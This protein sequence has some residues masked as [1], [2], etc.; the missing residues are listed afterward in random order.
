MKSLLSYLQNI[1]KTHFLTEKILIVDSYSIG[2]QIL[3]QLAAEGNH[4]VNLKVKTV[5]DL[6][7]EAFTQ[8]KKD[9]I[10]DSLGS[11]FMY[12]LLSN[13][14]SN[15]VL[16]YFNDVEVT[17]ALSFSMYQTI[18][19]LR[20]AGYT[21]VTLK[22]E[23]FVTSEKG[24]DMIRI[25]SHYEQLLE[26]HQ[27]IDDAMLY[28]RVV[29][30]YS[31]LGKVFILQSNL[32]LSALQEDFLK[33]I[34]TADYY[35]LP[36]EKV[37]GIEVPSNSELSNVVFHGETTLSYLYEVEK[38]PTK[39]TNLSLFSAQTEETELKEML[40]R[41]KQSGIRFDEAA[42]FYTAS[43]QYV[44]SMYHL[45]EK[46][47]IPVT[48]G[49]GIPL[50]YTRPGKFVTGLLNW[51]K[52]SYSVQAFITLLQENVM[53]T[54]EGAP[55]KT[56]WAGLL[57]EASIGWSPERYISQLQDQI[58]KYEEKAQDELE[59]ERQAYFQKKSQEFTWLL[60]WFTSI[61]KHMPT[62]YPDGMLIYAEQLKAIRHMLSSFGKV[63]S[64]YDQAAKEVMLEKIDELLPYANEEVLLSEAFQ[65]I[66]E[67]LLTSNV[68][69]S[70]PKP[71]HLHIS[72]YK[73]GLYINREHIFIVGLDNQRFPGNAQE[74][75][76]LLDIER[77]KLGKQ[78][79]LEKEKS[80]RNLY[81]MLQLFASAASKQITVSYCKFD[82]NENRAITPAYLFLQC[83]RIQSGQHAADFKQL[84]EEIPVATEDMTL[85]SGDWWSKKLMST[86][87]H[88]L[89][90]QLL[91]R[92]TNVER[93]L[94]A[95][96]MRRDPAFTVFEG[97][98]ESDTTQFDPRRNSE[99]SISA[100]KLEAIAKCPYSYFLENVLRI[101]V[102]EDVTY[103]PGKW[104][105]AKTRG[106]LL[107]EIFEKFYKVIKAKGEKPS[108]QRHFDLLLSLAKN[109]I[110]NIKSIVPPPNQRVFEVE[111]E[112]IIESCETFLRIEEENSELGEPLYFEYSFGQDSPAVIELP[113]GKINV[114]GIID[115]VDQL[116]DGSF[117]IIDYKTGSSWG[118]ETKE[119]FK[120][121]R[122]LQHLLYT[123]A[124][125]SH[126]NLE[127][128]TVKKS[129]YFFPTRKGI[130]KR[131]ERDQEEIT[132]TNGKDILDKILTIVEHGHFTMTDDEMDCKFCD[133][134]TIC[135][136][137]TYDKEIFETKHQ[138][139]T[140]HGIKSFLGVRAYD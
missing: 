120:G 107:H 126:L 57:R 78:L 59:P 101:K 100:G 35:Q 43:S 115:R 88:Q 6:A 130:G 127:E 33:S 12:S 30:T 63:S 64:A 137:S 7:V 44:S 121:G 73:N 71:G 19:K 47:T 27:V 25:L 79:P 4:A 93:G 108:Y 118:Y 60:K 75:P 112:E 16:Q 26:D 123:L 124:I 50:I 29:G 46:L 104:L 11:H 55:S 132:R 48:F 98:I 20:L 51:M 21:G 103:D 95:E 138:D 22:E 17:P 110:E 39:V 69:Q 105:D 76:L 67:N 131:F 58:E 117:H 91:N 140:A 119:F 74:D 49:E 34:V 37:V 52:D 13:L 42:V 114:R 90:E 125:E 38:A 9:I 80:K 36:L 32:T 135:R 23:F 94:L 65:K 15:K 82:M 5:R 97:K 14:H 70:R 61:F 89:D 133:F 62:V 83:Y 81:L 102:I 72:T 8:R 3:F 40:T 86:S 31:S 68:G 139:Q 128:G 99:I 41:I 84:Q 87:V 96:E 1:C 111:F 134:K 54:G 113:T 24:K 53:D 109:Q 77:K 85:E 106:T 18:K 2:E 122:Q 129:T 56:K 10:T 45:S 136:R 116:P 28:K 66:Q 92:F